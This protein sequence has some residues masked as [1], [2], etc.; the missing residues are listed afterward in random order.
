MQRL[1][2]TELGKLFH[3]DPREVVRLIAHDERRLVIGDERVADVE[4]LV[5]TLTPV[6][7]DRVDIDVDDPVVRRGDLLDPRL[8]NGLAPRRGR[9]IGLTV[10]VSAELNPDIELAVMSQDESGEI[11]TEHQRG[12]GEVSRQVIPVE[13][14]LSGRQQ[15]EHPL[16]RRPLVRIPM[17][18]LLEFGP[19]VRRVSRELAHPSTQTSS[20][21]ASEILRLLS[22]MCSR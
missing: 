12:G 10:G 16:H 4:V 9:Q 14:R 22:P 18:V 7:R 5:R 11:A 3:G 21:T 1:L 15:P 8:F 20:A 19:Q 13:C 17:Q 2:F 6:R